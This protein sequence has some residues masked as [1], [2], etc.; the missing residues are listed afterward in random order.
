MTGVL[1]SV[2]YVLMNIL[3]PIQWPEYN[4]Y[5][6]TVSEL[7]ALGAPTRSVWVATGFVYTILIIAFG[8]GIRM[9]A[10]DS[11]LLRMSGKFIWIYGF[12]S[13]LWPFAP[14][15]LRGEGYS[16]TDILHIALGM[17]TLL[18]MILAMIFGAMALKVGFRIYTIIS[19]AAF[20]FFGAL[21]G[22]DAPRIKENLSTPFVGLWE[23]INIS[24]F[25]I[26]VAVFAIV[27]ITK[28][29]IHRRGFSS[30]KK[31]NEARKVQTLHEMN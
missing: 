19:M 21:T 1:S 31:R 18:C 26:W 9:S 15:H 24:A 25:L 11:G 14:M 17:I 28:A 7:S 10:G 12:V 30:E 4:I 13:L 5:S 16:T 23:R 2:L 6:Q 8:F 29:S 22:M 27:M 20:L 3:I